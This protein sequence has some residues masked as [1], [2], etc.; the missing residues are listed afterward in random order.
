MIAARR[1]DVA[2]LNSRAR[3]RLQ[4]D[5][6]LT[7]PTY[8]TPN[9]T[10]FQTGDTIVCLRNDHDRG[11]VNGM[12]A[13]IVSINPDDRRILIHTLDNDRPIVLYPEYVDVGH[14]DHGYAITA[15]KA[16]GMTCEATFVLADATITREWG[17]VALSRGRH[18]NRMY[19][20]DGNRLDL[21]PDDTTHP[22]TAQ[23][24]PSLADTLIAKLRRTGKQQLA[25][26]L[27]ADPEIAERV[28]RRLHDVELHHR[29]QEH[30][31]DRDL[32]HGIGL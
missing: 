11:V 1:A 17:Y 18:I 28:A 19:L 24:E 23:P 9:G 13:T 22:G 29:H 5:G 26:E 16:Q 27:Q 3:Q 2:D 14:V 6:T 20:A 12:R 32:G 10:V 7:G 15:H 30:E 8:L 21:D 25:D 31:L 4:A